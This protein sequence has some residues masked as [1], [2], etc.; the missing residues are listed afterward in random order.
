[1]NSFEIKR[2]VE[3]YEADVTGKLALPMILNWAVLASKL[4]SDALGVGQSTHLARGLGW[5]ILQYEVHI[6]R[7]PAVNEEITIQTYAAKYNPFFVRRPFAFFDAQ[8][9]EI[10]RVDSIWTM[11]D[12]NNRRMARLPQ[13]IVDKYQAE[14]VKQ[15]PRMPN[16]IKILPS[17]DMI[18]K[19]YHVRYL[20]I[21]ANQ[22]VNN[23]KYFEWMQDVVPTEFL[24]THEITSINLKYENEIHLGHTI[25]SQVVLGNQSSKHRIM[26]GEVVSAE[27]EFNWRNVTL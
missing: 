26:L 14:R 2:R 18:S 22:H 3:Y 1:M 8:G 6:T 20:D 13:D 19:D 24:E 9:E 15:I 5:I 27:A 17:D 21:D 11:I 12:I 16:P 4:Q 23:S 25:Q 10:I 7:R